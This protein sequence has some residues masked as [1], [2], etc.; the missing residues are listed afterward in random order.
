MHAL[1]RNIVAKVIFVAAAI[2]LPVCFFFL[3]WKEPPDIM[4]W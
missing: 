4:N 2:A 1:R 3:W